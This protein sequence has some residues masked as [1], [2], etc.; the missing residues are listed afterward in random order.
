MRA[1]SSLGK[2]DINTPSGLRP[3][4]IFLRLA[5]ARRSHS[6]WDKTIGGH[7]SAGEDYDLAML[8]ECSQELGIPA[9]IVSDKEFD[10]ATSSTNLNVLAI[11]KRLVFLDNFKSKR[12]MQNG[13]QWTEPGLSIFYIGYYDG[14]IQFVDGE[15]CGLQI[16]SLEEIEKEI[17]EKPEQFTDDIRYMVEKFKARIKPIENKFEHMLND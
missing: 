6:L 8:K 17:K 11:L 3:L 12:T 13:N 10:N 16:F 4:I 5:S 2:A 7:V 9:T 1:P 14:P 15:S